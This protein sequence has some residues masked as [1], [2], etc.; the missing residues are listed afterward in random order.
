MGLHGAG[1]R[2]WDFGGYNVNNR[3]DWAWRR[4]RKSLFVIF[5][6]YD[7]V[8]EK[9]NLKGK[10]VQFNSQF[11]R[12]RLVIASLLCFIKLK[13][14]QQRAKIF[15]WQ[16]QGSRSLTHRSL[17]GHPRYKAALSSQLF[18]LFCFVLFCFVCLFVFCFLRQDFSV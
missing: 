15:G 11:R 2:V 5:Q 10:K 4:D 1:F 18:V 3:R 7:K 16:H 14:A 17:G 6:L 13:T 8:P 9:I 12:L